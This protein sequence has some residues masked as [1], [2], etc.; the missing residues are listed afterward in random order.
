MH[1]LTH[2][3]KAGG[4]TCEKSNSQVHSAAWMEKV[5]KLPKPPVSVPQL[6]LP[7]NT[8][9]QALRGGAAAQHGGTLCTTPALQPE[10]E[11][12]HAQ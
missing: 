8:H 10:L 1:A 6:P 3:C 9:F 5:G 2:A 11:Y 4:P 12:G 7:V